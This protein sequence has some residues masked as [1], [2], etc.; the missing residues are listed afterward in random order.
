MNISRVALLGLFA[1]P[2]A[3]PAFA[4]QPA[5]PPV[6][7]Q[8]SSPNAPM[9][10]EKAASIH[11]LLELSGTASVSQLAVNQMFTTMQTQLPQVPSEFWAKTR[12][13]IHADDLTNSL[14][15]IYSREYTQDNLN[16]LIAFYQ[17]PLGRKVVATQP[18]ILQA[19]SAVSQQWS[20]QILQELIPEI[21][22]EQAAKKAHAQTR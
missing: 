1:L 10:A 7:A 17:S 16:G 5:P 14:I 21:R 22:R 4:Q 13:H 15:P 12:T 9:S 3:A 2:Y 8:A 6:A 11:R 20:R 18:E 19:S